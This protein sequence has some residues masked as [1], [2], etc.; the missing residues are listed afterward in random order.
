MA[1]YHSRLKAFPFLKIFLSIAICP[2]LGLIWNYDHS[3]F[4][5]TGGGSIGKCGRLSQPSWLFVHTIM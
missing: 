1:F 4:V 2:F 3:L 5:V